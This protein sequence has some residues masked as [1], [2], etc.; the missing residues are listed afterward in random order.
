[1][2][3]AEYSLAVVWKRQGGQKGGRSTLGKCTKPGGLTR[4]YSGHDWVIWVAA[5]HARQLKLDVHQ[6]EALLYHELLHCALEGDPPVPAI[7]G[8][9]VEAF[10]SEVEEYGLWKTDLAA[11]GTVFGRQLSLEGLAEG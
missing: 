7:V 8:H 10:L 5:D 3:I 9:D 2:F 1:M 11:A 4:F 6:V